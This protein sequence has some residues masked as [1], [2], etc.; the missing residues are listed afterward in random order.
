VSISSGPSKAFTHI[1]FLRLVI[2]GEAGLL[3]LAW[4]LAR[5]LDVSPLGEL[6]P[7]LPGLFWGALATLPLLLGLAWM[8]GSTSD[9]VRKLV[10]LVVEQIGPLL[11]PLSLLELGL[12]ALMAGFCEEILFRGVIQVG[13]TRWMSTGWALVVTGLLFGLVH[14]ASRAYALFAAV[15]GWYL[16]TLFLAQDSLVP[17]IVTHSLYDFVA[18]IA[19]RQRSRAL[20]PHDHLTAV[21]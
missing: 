7:V 20:T 1:S 15:M 6:G 19:V 9:S 8:L 18:L 16:G 13:L 14:F 5:W 4:A 2:S 11:A 3:L 21:G 17:P 10:N 12:L